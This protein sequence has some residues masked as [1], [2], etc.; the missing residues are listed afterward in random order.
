MTIEEFYQEVVNSPL[1]PDN[2][3]AIYKEFRL[4]Q[5]DAI[6]TLNEFHRICEK[7]NIRYIL[8]YGSLLGAVRDHGQVPWDYDVDVYIPYEERERL[9]SALDKELGNDYY[10]ECPENCRNFPSFMIRMSPKEYDTEAVHVDIF[11]IIGAP[12]EKTELYLF[13]ERMKQLCID[14]SRKKRNLQKL[15]ERDFKSLIIVLGGKIR[16]LNK[17]IS[18]IDK[19]LYKICGLYDPYKTGRSMVICAVYKNVFSY[20]TELLWKTR[21]IHTDC[22]TYRIPESYQD[23]LKALYG[24]YSNPLPLERRIE[25]LQHYY[26]LLKHLDQYIKDR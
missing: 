1:C 3:D 23:I 9:L 11:Y 6:R 13:S 14:R 21:L 17:P 19:E 15:P 25:E 10:Y 18:K 5:R 22:G 4:Y 16:R 8:G 2:F 20:D 12:D 7:H 26:K 24:D